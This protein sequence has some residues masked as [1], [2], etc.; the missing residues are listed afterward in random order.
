MHKGVSGT[1]QHSHQ[2]A[3]LQYQRKMKSTGFIFTGSR[4]PV[5]KPACDRPQMPWG[6]AE[7]LNLI[8][9]EGNTFITIIRKDY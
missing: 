6:E 3:E 9:E 4:T 2:A 5:Q 7:V 1:L 8:C